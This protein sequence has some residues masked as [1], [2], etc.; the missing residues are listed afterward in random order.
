M[1][2]AGPL[3]R[4]VL[5]RKKC[6]PLQM[7]AVSLEMAMTEVMVTLLVIM[8]LIEGVTPHHSTSPADPAKVK[9]A[10]SMPGAKRED[11]INI[12][13]SRDGAI[14]FDHMATHVEDIAEH[15]RQKVRAGSERRA[16]LKVD[17]RAKYGDV[18]TVIDAIRGG[19]LWNIGLLVEQD[20]RASTQP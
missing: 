8:M 1:K 20:Q 9:H 13:I 18:G 14:Y 2:S 15:I 5:A 19:G 11:A 17:Q 6:K 3:Q 7:V 10:I 16:Y 12:L 4:R